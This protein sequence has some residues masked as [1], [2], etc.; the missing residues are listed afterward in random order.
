MAKEAKTVRAAALSVGIFMMT[1][2]AGSVPAFANASPFLR[3]GETLLSGASVQPSLE[4]IGTR[5]SVPSAQLR[6]V[7]R[8]CHG[9]LAD[10]QSA[11]RSFCAAGLLR[12]LQ[13]SL[14]LESAF[15]GGLSKAELPPANL[16]ADAAPRRAEDNSDTGN[17]IVSSTGIGM[18]PF[19]RQR[20]LGPVPFE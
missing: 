10:V 1:G 18:L 2:A 5:D 4:N 11:T 15:A 13:F 19:I 8:L 16:P 6:N 9:A 3:L 20:R 17:W 12:V 14:V 7:A